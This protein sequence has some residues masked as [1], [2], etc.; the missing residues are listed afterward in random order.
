MTRGAVEEAGAD[1][2]ADR[3]ADLPGVARRAD[4]REAGGGGPS[5]RKNMPRKVRNSSG[6]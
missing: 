1:R 4:R 2:I 5:G 3:E 6:L